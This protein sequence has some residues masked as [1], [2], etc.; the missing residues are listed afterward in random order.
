[1][2]NI[3]NINLIC[4]G[5]IKEKYIEEG[6]AEYIKRMKSYAVFKIV[7]LKEEGN[8]KERERAM[9]IEASEIK[10]VLE[11][12]KG[13]NI[14]LDIKGKHYTTEEFV[15][16]IESKTVHGISTINFI[17][18]GSYGVTDEIRNLSE[19][20]LSFSKFTFPHQLMRLLFLEQLYR[21]FSIINNSKYHK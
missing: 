5:R 1:V 4:I 16:V 17:I 13:L 18:G 19:I 6:M 15:E 21:W 3:V 2:F 20:R 8:D 11:K 14:L 9:E 7:E 10:K 12:N